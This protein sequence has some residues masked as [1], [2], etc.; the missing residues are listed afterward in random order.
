[1]CNHCTCTETM[2]EEGTGR[3]YCVECGY[4][5]GIIVCNGVETVEEVI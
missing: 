1:M 5:T 3:E 2:V 4:Y